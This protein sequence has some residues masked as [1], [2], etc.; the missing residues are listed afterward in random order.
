MPQVTFNGTKINVEFTESSSRQ[1]LNSGENISTLF[2]KI[3]K[4][5][6]DLK[7]VCFSGSYNDLSNK[8]SSLPANGGNADYAADADKLDGLHA[9][10]FARQY[11][12]EL[13]VYLNGQSGDIRALVHQLP[14]GGYALYTIDSEYNGITF[15]IQGYCLMSWIPSKSIVNNYMYGTLIIRPMSS[16][17][18]TYICSVYNTYSYTD[19]EQI[20][21]TPIKSTTFSATA[22]ETGNFNL[23]APSENKVP[24]SIQLDSKTFYAVPFLY[25]N[26]VWLGSTINEVT[27]QPVTNTTVSGTVYYIEV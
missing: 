12:N 26:Q 20:S 24:I 11:N 3:K 21:T 6:S 13:G 23:W 19:W 10:E 7:A 14:I 9:D 22:D 1:Q 18:A 15:P 16:V 27:R 2:G 5:F 25:N 8:P 17:G 4:I